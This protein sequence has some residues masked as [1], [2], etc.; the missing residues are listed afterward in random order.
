MV[1]IF[2]ALSLLCAF[3]L[4]QDEVLLEEVTTQEDPLATKVKSFLSDK[5]YD[6]N[7]GFINVIFD[8]KSAFYQN[9]RVDAVKVVQ[10]LKENGLLKLFFKKPQ[11]FRLNFKTNGSPLFF[12]KLMGDLRICDRPS[13]LANT[14]AKKRL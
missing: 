6:E 7:K 11:E 10:T 9:D 14:T 13:C 8:P 1:K 2:L 12:V 3:L 5:T 4:A